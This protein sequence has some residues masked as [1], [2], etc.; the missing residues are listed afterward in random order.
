MATVLSSTIT[1]H[2]LTRAAEARGQETLPQCGGA[3]EHIRKRAHLVDMLIC[4]WLCEL[5]VIEEV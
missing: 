2:L 3:A 4:G 5:L 1:P